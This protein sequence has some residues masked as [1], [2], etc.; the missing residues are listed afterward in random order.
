MPTRTSR[1]S[2]RSDGVAFVAAAHTTTS[3]RLRSPLKEV[4]RARAAR[5][6]ARVDES[7]GL[8][9][10][11]FANRDGE[12][13]TWR[14]QRCSTDGR[15]PRR[16]ES[17]LLASERG[18]SRRGRGGWTGSHDV[19]RA[20]RPHRDVR[21]TLSRGWC[22]CPRA[23]TY[24]RVHMHAC[25]YV[26]ERA[27]ACASDEHVGP[28]EAHAHREGVVHPNRGGRYTHAAGVG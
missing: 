10:A 17:R 24:T 18:G 5:G 21:A 6:V 27:R 11:T 13:R 12:P 9:V 22:A 4:V 26:N 7:A 16:G 28:S 3:R 14:G 1:P 20:S 8:Y 23:C 25:V 19:V 15:G 2:V